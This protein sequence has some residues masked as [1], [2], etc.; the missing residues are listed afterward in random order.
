MA[1]CVKLI[2]ILILAV[3]FGGGASDAFTNQLVDQSAIASVPVASVEAEMQNIDRQGSYIPAP[4]LPY[5]SDAEIASSGGTTQLLTFSRA[6]RSYTTEFILSLKGVVERLA[7]REDA[8]SL[9]REKLFDTSAFYRC[10]PVSA[11]YVFALRHI[12]I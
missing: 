3:A 1:K 2:L 8:L 12:I 6:Q 7:L 4:Q 10:S 11:Y 5:I 9:H